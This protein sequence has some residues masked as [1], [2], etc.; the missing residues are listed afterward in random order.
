M[1]GLPG[2]LG[3]REMEEPRKRRTPPKV[4]EESF[5]EIS[6]IPKGLDESD[7]AIGDSSNDF[8]SDFGSLLNALT[9]D[10]S[11]GLI[12]SQ[13]QALQSTEGLQEALPSRQQAK[14]ERALNYKAAVK[15]ARK[16]IPQLHRNAES[17]QVQFGQISRSLRQTTSALSVHFQPTNDFETEMREA[18]AASGVTEQRVAESK[19]LPVAPGIKQQRINSHVAQLKSILFREQQKNRRINKIKSKMWRKVNR[20]SELME[21]ERLLSRLE[22]ES[23]ELAAKI[24]ADMEEKRAGMRMLKRQNARR[25]WA[26]VA[27]RYG[28]KDAQKLVSREAQKERDEMDAITRI[29]KSS[30]H[31]VLK[32]DD[33]SDLDFDSEDEGGGE[34]VLRRAKSLIE[35][36]VRSDEEDTTRQKGLM[37]LKFM[38]DA[39]KREKLKNKEEADQ[40]MK[41]IDGLKKCIK[42]KLP[43]NS[44][45]V[46][47]DDSDVEEPKIK[48]HK[49]KKEE[50][51]RLPR[52][53]K[54]ELERAARELEESKTPGMKT[55]RDD[56]KITRDDIKITGDEEKIIEDESRGD[57]VADVNGHVDGRQGKEN[58]HEDNKDGT[59]DRHLNQKKISGEKKNGQ[60]K[61]TEKNT[62]VAVDDLVAM[63]ASEGV[64]DGALEQENLIQEAFVDSE[65]IAEQNEM[66]ELARED[67]EEEKEKEQGPRKLAGWGSWTGEGI[68]DRKKNIIETVIE[69]KPKPRIYIN[70][71][72]DRKL[73]PYFVKSVPFPY[74][75]KEQ[76]EATCAHPLGPE[77]NASQVHNRLIQPDVSIRAGTVIM[78][79]EYAKHLPKDQADSLLDVWSGRGKKKAPKAR[80]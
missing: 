66:K 34:E 80:L 24:R 13:L 41:E 4:Q 58:H 77:W 30:P 40:V 49:G 28:G 79:L 63:L 47:T 27:M 22:E 45:D 75:N 25:K 54:E 5:E 36:E 70:R 50:P 20:K 14:A 43:K 69:E 55:T 1:T 51:L 32:S 53:T 15:D 16:W 78:P 10:K 74:S 73:A 60:E 52:F 72:L 42:R 31:D 17:E 6:S 59:R 35:E 18:I 19:A 8:G 76:F 56:I 29:A 3:P 71:K 21:R 57:G 68:K 11:L 39:M 7:F 26:Q 65:Q 37:G 33:E 61:H 23:P 9:D 48:K 44:V 62:S 46:D 67:E 2:L 12:K 64:L 38:Q